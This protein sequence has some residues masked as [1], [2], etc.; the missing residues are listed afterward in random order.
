MHSVAFGHFP[1][2]ACAIAL[3]CVGAEVLVSSGSPVTDLHSYGLL[4]CL[5]YGIW[6]A[7]IPR[8]DWSRDNVG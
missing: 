7:I 6:V 5:Q 1:G 3:P 8:D 4:L 2:R